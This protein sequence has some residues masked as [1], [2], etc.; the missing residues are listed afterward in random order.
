MRVLALVGMAGAVDDVA[1]RDHHVEGGVRGVRRLGERRGGEDEQRRDGEDRR[2][3]ALHE[4][5]LG[6]KY[7]LGHR[8]GAQAQPDGIASGPRSVIEFP[9]CR[10]YPSAGR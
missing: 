4:R 8:P 5:L 2:L 1:V 6:R 9:N 3:D 7:T 10:S